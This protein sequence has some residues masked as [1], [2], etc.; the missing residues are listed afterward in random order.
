MCVLPLAFLQAIARE[1]EEVERYTTPHYRA[2][3]MVDLHSGRRV[4][5]AVDVWALGC[6]LY[7][8]C[9]MKTPFED[10]SGEAAAGCLGRA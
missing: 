7:K 1:E 4:D 3:E 2:P 5:H 9:F 6:L 10:A 8:L